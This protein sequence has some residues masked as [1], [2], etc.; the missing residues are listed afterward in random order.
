MKRF[1]LLVALAA[2]AAPGAATAKPV[3]LKT[4]W[5]EDF[6]FTIGQR[7]GTLRLHV[8]RLE[9]SGTTWTAYVGLTNTSSAPLS[10][11]TQLEKSH[12]NQPFVYWA[13]P[14]IWWSTIDHS[15]SWYPGGGTVLT[16]VAKAASIKPAYPKT[17]GA[18]KSWFGAF[19]GPVA[20][21]D[22]ERLLRIGF[23]VIVQPPVGRY[24]DGRP[25][26]ENLPVSTTHQFK[27]P[28]RL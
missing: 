1:L 24:P 25:L 22:K 8:R 18:G 15:Q 16:N 9:F 21:V 20:K 11:A 10:I 2:L 7:H 14:G 19:S 12:W 4:N 23:G 17:L 27:L 13:G 5:N 3:V 26:Y 6:A 28:H